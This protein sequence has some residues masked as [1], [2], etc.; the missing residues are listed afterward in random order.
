MAAPIGG[1][2]PG[3]SVVVAVRNGERHLAEA[4]ASVEAQSLPPGEVV[5]VDGQSTDR[6]AAIARS[7]ER[8]VYVRQPDLGLANPRNLGIARSRLPLI[9]FFY[10]DDHWVPDKLSAQV[11][12]LI[13]RPELLYVTSAL[14]L[15]LEA[16]ASLS[17]RRSAAARSAARTGS[18]PSALLAWRR[19][20]DLVGPFDSSYRIGCDADWFAR[21]RDL[22][23]A[24]A[25]FPRALVRK[26]LHGQNLSTAAR[27]NRQELFQVA[28]RSLARQRALSEYPPRA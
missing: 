9:A 6:T 21:A 20:F 3:V 15:L 1:P 7:F 10:Q 14:E 5:V 23:A 13:S 11:A 22:G 17:A 8:V 18:T 28:R 26:R 24:S 19:A 12:L 4:L 16:G 25:A 27:V 2:P